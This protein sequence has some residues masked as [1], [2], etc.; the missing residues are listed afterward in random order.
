MLLQL[1]A[2]ELAKVWEAGG[3]FEGERGRMW[4]ESIPESAEWFGA[5][6]TRN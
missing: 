5:G 3:E 4:I 2:V 1:R 6:Q